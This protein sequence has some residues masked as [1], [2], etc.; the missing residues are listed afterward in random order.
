MREVLIVDGYNIIGA[1]S[2]LAES[3]KESLELAR[4]QLV[5]ILTEFQSFTGMEVI[6][7]FDAHLAAGAR[8][9]YQSGKVQV[10]FSKEDETAD[11]MIERF[12]HE[13]E[14]RTSHIYVAT[15]DL[16]EQQVTFGEGALRISA[17]ELE[18]RVI[19][20]RKSIRK[21]VDKLEKKRNT[22][23]DQLNEEVAEIFEKW[24]RKDID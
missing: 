8:K 5:G 17:R 6:V 3:K 2:Q 18:Q 9:Q 23:G 7:V 10:Y 24:R 1:W 19:E 12:V 22:L 4:D 16:V 11:E 21:E 14:K 15:S 13:M 20:A